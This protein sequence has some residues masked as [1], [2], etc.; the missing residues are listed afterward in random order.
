M[1]GFGKKKSRPLPSE[2]SGA[3]DPL[4]GLLAHFQSHVLKNPATDNATVEL[5]LDDYARIVGIRG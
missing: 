1:F 3:N 4:L 2:M 5:D